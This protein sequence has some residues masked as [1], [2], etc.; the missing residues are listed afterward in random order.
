M[1]PLAQHM[2]LIASLREAWS[3]I[4]TEAATKRRSR[5]TPVAGY[6]AHGFRQGGITQRTY[7]KLR[8]LERASMQTLTRELKARSDHIAEAVRRLVAKGLARRKRTGF[9]EIV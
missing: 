5:F 3:K 4:D 1:T 6:D 7:H 8:E 9:Y 2:H